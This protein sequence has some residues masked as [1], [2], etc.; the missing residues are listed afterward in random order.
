MAARPAHAWH[1][2][3][4]AHLLLIPPGFL[5]PEGPWRSHHHPPLPPSLLCWELPAPNQ[6]KKP[7]SQGL[8]DRAHSR[9]GGSSPGEG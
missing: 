5:A 8:E 1:Q 9:W 7:A 2:H 3:H 6:T 4:P